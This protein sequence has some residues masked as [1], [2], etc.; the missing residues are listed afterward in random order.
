MIHS[1]QTD[2]NTPTPP[3][4]IESMI[5]AVDVILSAFRV[6]PFYVAEVIGAAQK[7]RKT[8]SDYVD[9]I[10]LAPASA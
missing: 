2:Q 1:I 10:I 4:Y 3:T 8:I 5:R 6:V 9:C 7:I